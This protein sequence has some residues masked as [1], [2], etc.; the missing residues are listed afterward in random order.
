M[1]KAKH[2]R[3]PETND[4]RTLTIAGET[5]QV[6]VRYRAG[7]VLTEGEAQALNQAYVEAVRNN[8]A[9]KVRSFPSIRASIGE[10]HS[11]ITW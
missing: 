3:S 10:S 9:E 6:P 8:N 1:A 4:V 7:H 11:L 2:A 5:F